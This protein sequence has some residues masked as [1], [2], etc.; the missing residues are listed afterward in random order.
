MRACQSSTTLICSDRDPQHQYCPV[1]TE[2]WCK[3]NKALAICQNVAPNSP[4]I[5]ADLKQYVK[6]VFDDLSNGELL[7]KYLLGSTQNRD[8]CFN[9]LVWAHAPK[10]E[11]VT[12]LT[13]EVAVSH[14]V[15]VFNSDRQTL[16]LVMER[17][18]IM[19]G[20][21]CISHLVSQN[22]YRTKRAQTRES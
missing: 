10:T 4:T 6:P 21:L 3:Y 7:D 14:Y 12:R 1:C 18:G 19:D 22:A 13:I 15:L 2:N 9:S 8:E 16:A 17:L 11:Y 20:P 5:P